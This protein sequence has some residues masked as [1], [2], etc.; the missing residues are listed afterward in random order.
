MDGP[1]EADVEIW[2]LD[3][4]EFADTRNLGWLSP[5]EAERRDRFVRQA[6]RDRFALGRMLGRAALARRLGR[7]PEDIDF[8]ID[9]NGRPRLVG[10]GAWFSLSHSGALVAAAVA[11]WPEV[12]LDIEREDE[13]AD[14]IGVAASVFTDEEREAIA[15]AP[16]DARL[17][18]FFSLWTL[19]EA[20][21]KATGMGFGLD[22]RDCAFD[23][24]ELPR[25][26]RLAGSDPA[27]CESW[28]FRQWRPRTG[29]PMALA[30]RPPAG[31]RPRIASP[32]PAGGLLAEF[33]GGAA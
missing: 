27:E 15:A 32:T 31:S 18:L 29:Y 24:A 1:P 10:D 28:L 30:L 20:Y 33:A 11:P 23:P 5:A 26:L 6:D 13:G 9:S 16:G 4:T 7:R 8:E 19:K 17:R 22:A 21:L 3:R 14:L 12:G 2:W 25:V